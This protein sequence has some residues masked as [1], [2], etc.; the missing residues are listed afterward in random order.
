MEIGEKIDVEQIGCREWDDMKGFIQAIGRTMVVWSWGAE[1]WT[2][3]NDYVLRFKVNG[4]NHKGHVYVAVNF[5]DLFDVYLTDFDGNI[6]EVLK[7]VYLMDFIEHVDVAVESGNQK[8]YE[9]S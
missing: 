6:V 7:D 9:K 2:K 8:Y 1:Q 5:M 3:M 4:M